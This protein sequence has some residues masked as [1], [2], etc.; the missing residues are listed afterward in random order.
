[1]EMAEN[2]LKN[3]GPMVCR[4][5]LKFPDGRGL[6]GREAAMLIKLER[7]FESDLLLECGGQQA[8][9]NSIMGLLSLDAD[10]D[11]EVTATATGPDANQMIRAVEEFFT[12]GFCPTPEIPAASLFRRKFAFHFD[13]P[14]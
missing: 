7:S 3:D 11:A 13:L 14:R 5:H 6:H 8:R 4:A 12:N 2:I 9:A 10:G 1:M